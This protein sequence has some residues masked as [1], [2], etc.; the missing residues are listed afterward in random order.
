MVPVQPDDGADDALQ[1]VMRGL[2]AS[3]RESNLRRTAVLESALT[4]LAAGALT[5]EQRESAVSAAHQVAAGSCNG[6]KR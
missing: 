3:A 4:A 5:A 1:A 6:V 2:A